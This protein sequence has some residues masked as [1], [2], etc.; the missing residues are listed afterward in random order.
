VRFVDR[1]AGVKIEAL[2]K[3]KVGVVHSFVVLLEVTV[4]QSTL[5]SVLEIEQSWRLVGW[6][7]SSKTCPLVV[8]WKIGAL[9][10]SDSLLIEA[11]VL[12]G[13]SLLVREFEQS[14][15]LLG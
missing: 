10:I 15:R 9:T 12:E 1:G 14:W 7:F 6:L 5:V 4:S 8:V 11:V 2:L 3:A 13:L